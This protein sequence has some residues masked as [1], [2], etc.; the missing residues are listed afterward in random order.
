MVWRKASAPARGPSSHQDG[1]LQPAPAPGSVVRRD[2][3]PPPSPP[4]PGHLSSALGYAPASPVPPPMQ[5][6]IVVL[7]RTDSPQ[8]HHTTSIATN[9]AP[10]TCLI[11]TSALALQICWMCCVMNASLHIAV[12][13]ATMPPVVAVADLR[14]AMGA[15]CECM[16]LDRFRPAADVVAPCRV[17]AHAGISSAFGKV[18]HPRSSPALLST[19]ASAIPYR[20]ILLASISKCWIP[21]AMRSI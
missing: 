7:T 14:L 2:P 15:G 3:P 19:A 17:G 13:H 10:H 5:P 20:G 12:P 1:Q 4:A 11:T 8:T 21:I 9:S 18:A 6:A 16:L